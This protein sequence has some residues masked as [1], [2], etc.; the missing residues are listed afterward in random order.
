MNAPLAATIDGEPLGDE[1]ARALWKRFSAWMDEHKGDL[2]GFATS[3]GLASVHPE[4]HGERAVLAGSRTGAQRAYASAP[5]TGGGVDR[6]G[7]DGSGRIQSGAAGK[8]R[9]KQ[10]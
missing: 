5:A 1:E 2:A 3:E 9:R 8:R 10:R 6:P 4:M 7:S